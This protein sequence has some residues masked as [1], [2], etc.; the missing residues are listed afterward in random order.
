MDRNADG[1]PMLDDYA[2]W[3]DSANTL[4][5]WTQVVGKVRLALSP[6]LNH[7]WQVPL[8]V[9]VHGLGTSAIHVGGGLLEIGFDFVGHRLRLRSSDAVERGF[10]LEPMSVSQ[11]YRRV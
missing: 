6:W 4:Q 3:R 9:D 8:Y 10:A 7:G 2:A 5:L 1:W 11:F